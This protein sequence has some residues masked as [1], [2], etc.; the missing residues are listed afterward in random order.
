M[1]IARS[2]ES[3]IGWEVERDIFVRRIHVADFSDEL[4]G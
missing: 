3:N 1:D 2:I 4:N